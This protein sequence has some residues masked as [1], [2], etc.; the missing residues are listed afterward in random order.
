MIKLKMR[1]KNKFFKKKDGKH[2]RF[3]KR[4]CRYRETGVPSPTVLK[5]STHMVISNCVLRN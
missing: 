4:K 1:R 3:H 2:K 5:R